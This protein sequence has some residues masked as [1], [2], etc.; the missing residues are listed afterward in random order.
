MA[1]HT[2]TR[3]LLTASS[4]PWL[5][6]AHTHPLPPHTHLQAHTGMCCIFV[7]F[8]VAVTE[9]WSIKITAGTSDWLLI[10]FLVFSGVFPPWSYLVNRWKVPVNVNPEL[11][12]FL[13][14][15]QHWQC[16]LCSVPS[17]HSYFCDWQCG[18]CPVISPQSYFCDWPLY[19]ERNPAADCTWWMRQFSA[20]H[21]SG[22]ASAKKGDM[23]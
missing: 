15:L 9:N 7:L 14:E 19:L 4:F 12:I 22:T 23:K 20:R 3:A 8:V 11:Y 17:P 1:I 10:F 18:L 6:H 2:T 5:E 21:R 13:T 16:G